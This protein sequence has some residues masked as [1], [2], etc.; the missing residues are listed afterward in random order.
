MITGFRHN[1]LKR[2]CERGDESRITAAYRT[3]VRRILTALDS[4]RSP[5]DLRM[6]WGLHALSGNLKGFWSVTVSRNWRII[7]R[8]ADKNVC[9]VDLIDYH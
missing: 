8:F 3:K 9:D 5:D 4:A 1:G 2:F 7:F 6:D